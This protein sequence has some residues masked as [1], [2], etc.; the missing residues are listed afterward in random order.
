MLPFLLQCRIKIVVVSGGPTGAFDFKEKTRM[1]H[2]VLVLLA[3]LMEHVS[4]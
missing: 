4:P 1:L 3:E 2:G